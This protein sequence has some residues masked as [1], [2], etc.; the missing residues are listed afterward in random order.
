MIECSANLGRRTDLDG[1]LERVHAAALATGVFPLGGLRTRVAERQR[2]RI[3][4]GDPENA[5][6]HVVVRIGHGRDA[7][8]KRAA[9]EAIFAALCGH[10]EPVFAE[11]PLGI[12]LE[13]QEIDPALSFKH[14]NLHDYVAARRTT[15]P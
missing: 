15:R 11:T 10:L 8:T 12:S 1:L 14:N 7:A 3:A 4:D 5:F 13:M 9:A 6:C 2:Y